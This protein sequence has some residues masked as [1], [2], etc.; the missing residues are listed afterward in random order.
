MPFLLEYQKKYSEPSCGEKSYVAG[1][2]SL[3]GIH[4][5]LQLACLLLELAHC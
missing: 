2:D 3:R 5:N 1:C 4:G